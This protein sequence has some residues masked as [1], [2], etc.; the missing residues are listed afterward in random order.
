MSDR[1]ARFA[2]LYAVL[3]TAAM[4]LAAPLLSLSY[5][6]TSEGADEL[7]NGTVSGW[8]DPAGEHLEGLLTWASPDRVYASFLQVFSVCFP[9]VLLCAIAIRRSRVV[10]TGGERWGWRLALTGYGLAAVGIVLAGL[11]LVGASVTGDA[12]NIVFLALMVPG[13]LI[14]SIG[15][16]VL[17]IALLRSPQRFTPRTTAWLL[18]LS[19]PAMAVIPEVLGHNSLGLLTMILAWGI[20]GAGLWRGE[21]QDVVAPAAREAVEH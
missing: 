9:A 18:A 14:S 3:A 17:G 20:A 8:A 15:S 4:F 13:M 11:V 6:A 21:P 2:G 7:D 5:F 12:L 16:T 1:T 10:A 19:F